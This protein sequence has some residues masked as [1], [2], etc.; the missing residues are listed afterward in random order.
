L[1]ILPHITVF[2]KHY[3]VIYISILLV[4]HLHLFIHHHLRMR[5]TGVLVVYGVDAALTTFS[6][7]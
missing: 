5:A 2:L 1:V 6:Y 7:I 4:E 3:S